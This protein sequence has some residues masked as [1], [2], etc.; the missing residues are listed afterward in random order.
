M[1][2]VT[3]HDLLSPQTA[4]N[5]GT[6]RTPVVVDNDVAFEDAIS[7]GVDLAKEGGARIGKNLL[8]GAI[9][10]YEEAVQTTDPSDGRAVPV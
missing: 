10:V 1:P 9:A 4:T 5:P 7:N 2:G 8:D 3:R 6:V